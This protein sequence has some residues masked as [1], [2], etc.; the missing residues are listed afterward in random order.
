[1]HTAETVNGVRPHRHRRSL[2]RTTAQIEKARELRHT[3]T[4]TEQAAWSLL[5]SIKFKAFRF[6]RQHPV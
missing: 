2:A 4:D 3:P 6:R 5:R 1:M